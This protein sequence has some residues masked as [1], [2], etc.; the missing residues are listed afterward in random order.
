[1]ANKVLALEELQQELV[2][3]TLQD[4]CSYRMLRKGLHTM[5]IKHVLPTSSSPNTT[6]LRGFGFFKRNIIESEAK[7]QV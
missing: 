1:M 3:I 6:I 2:T 7:E 4:S 5:S